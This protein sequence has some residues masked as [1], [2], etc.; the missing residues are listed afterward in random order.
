MDSKQAHFRLCLVRHGETPWNVERRLQGHL[1]VPLNDTGFA[2][3]E[4]TGSHLAGQPFQAL[5]CSDLLRT[6]QTAA[7]V[8]RHL[9]LDPIVEPGLRERH[10]GA[11]QGLTYDEAAARYPE[12]YAR[13]QQREP[14][15]A[16]PEHGESLQGF[17][18]RIHATL[19]GLSAAYAGQTVV[20]ITH[21]GVLD[22]VHR[23]VIGEPL[24]T[25]RHFKIPNAGINWI[26]HRDG[27][28]ELVSWADDSH[29]EAARDELDNA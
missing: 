12:E 20:A 19:E 2:Q 7:A 1:D 13:F 4:A 11:F 23:Y 28:W 16:F 6:R 29:L 9:G 5:I 15:F 3:A 17:A 8:G 22:V 26:A 10:Y 14:D 24:D 21:G 27:A 18:E 25:H